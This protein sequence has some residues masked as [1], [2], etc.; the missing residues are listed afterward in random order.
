MEY[1]LILGYLAAT[2]TT[3]AFIPQVIRTIKT[4]STKDISLP[5]YLIFSFGV[6]FW[7]IYGILIEELP[8]ML[9][10]GITLVL[11]VIV[12]IQKIRYG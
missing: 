8:I 12:L 4:R 3:F 6:L 2:C 7:F 1:S 5:M 9:A 11:A 10:N